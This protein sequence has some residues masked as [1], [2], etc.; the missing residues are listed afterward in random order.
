VGGGKKGFLGFWQ[1][2]LWS[3]K[4]R[5]CGYIMLSEAECSF[6]TRVA[7][8]TH[9]IDNNVYCPAQQ[10][11]LTLILNTEDDNEIKYA[12][13]EYVFLLMLS[14]STILFNSMT[15]FISTIIRPLL[16]KCV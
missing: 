5:K 1:T 6:T 10:V 3:A 13:S 9:L 14:K 12:N 11:C 7:L 8:R 16:M 2:T 4:G 15:N